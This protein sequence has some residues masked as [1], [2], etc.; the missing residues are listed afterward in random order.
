MKTLSRRSLLRGSAGVGIALPFLDAMWPAGRS[1]WA[2][3][4]VPRRLYC[5]LNQNGT[6]PGTWFPTG[7]EKDFQLASSMASFAPLREHLIIPDGLTKMQ[8]GTADGT[9]HGRGHASAITGWTCS[10][11]NGIGDGASLDQVVAN[12]IGSQTRIKSLMTG[13]VSNYHFLHEGAKQVH[14]PEPDPKK[15]FDRLFTGFT[16]PAGGGGG[17]TVDPNATADLARLRA[18]KKSILDA[19]MEQY[20]KVAM[21]LGGGDKQRLEKHLGSIRQVEVELNN[22]TSKPGAAAMGCTKPEAPISSTDYQAIGKLNME[23]S[24]MAFAC[25]IT[26]VS[27]LQW[28]SHGQVFDWLGATEKHHPLAH[29]TG[30]AGADAQ[31]SKIV[32]WHAE[33]LAAF[34][35]KLKSFAEGDGTVLDH[36]IVLWT[37]EISVGSHKFNRGPFLMAS[38]KFPLPMGG[39]LQTG[40]L[41]KYNGNPHTSLLQSIALAMGAPKMTVFGDWDKGPLPG[42]Y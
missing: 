24:A 21:G 3:T 41:L 17:A 42:L 2:Q 1:A 8:R 27:G 32:A 18:R 25:D 34:C 29:Q 5:M 31:L 14:F 23:L 9:A 36:T 12:A 19:T 40:R 7:G 37:N 38:G 20:R 35:T 6:V 28:I 30:S 39:T 10:G 16:P 33:Q 4:N 13:R 15:N 26:R 22:T 11:K